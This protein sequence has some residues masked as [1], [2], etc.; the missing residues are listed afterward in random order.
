[1]PQDYARP[2]L[3]DDNVAS[4]E[5]APRAAEIGDRELAADVMARLHD[6]QEALD[7]AMARQAA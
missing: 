3:R 7:R 2:L 5:V 6:F 1:M 4:F